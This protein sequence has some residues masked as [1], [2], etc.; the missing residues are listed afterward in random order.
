MALESESSV[1]LSDVPWPC[2]IPRF[3]TSIHGFI[4]YELRG[5]KYEPSIMMFF[6]GGT[7]RF[8]FLLR[9]NLFLQLVSRVDQAENHV[10]GFDFL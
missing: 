8:I 4:E 6:V 5:K 2:F 3:R 9:L 1:N 7:T 10:V